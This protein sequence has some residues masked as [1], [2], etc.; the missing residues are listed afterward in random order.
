[1]KIK[2]ELQAEY[3]EYVNKNKDDYSKTVVD[4]GEIFGKLVDEG[5][6]FDEAERVML[7]TQIGDGL[8]GAMMGFLMSALVHF[9]EK[10]AEIKSWWNKRSG[11][12]PD[13]T[14]VNN[15]AIITIGE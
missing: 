4:C 14:G 6:T 13:E 8:T 5:K 11:G 10:G 12:T 1:M 9:H 7:D 2:P 3:R 15:P